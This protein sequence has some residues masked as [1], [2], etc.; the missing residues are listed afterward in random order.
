MYTSSISEGPELGERELP[1][2]MVALAA[3]AVCSFCSISIYLLTLE[4]QAYV[5]LLE[6]ITDISFP[7]NRPIHR[8]RYY[9]HMTKLNEIKNQDLRRYHGIMEFLFRAA[10]SVHKSILPF[11][12]MISPFGYTAGLSPPHSN[13]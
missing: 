2:L 10:R 1:Q 9:A 7:F 13:S 5:G 4:T 12:L 8:A 11:L 6:D 3:T